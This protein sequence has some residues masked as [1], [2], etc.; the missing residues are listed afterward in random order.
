[1]LLTCVKN[2]KLDTLIAIFNKYPD[3][4]VS[5]SQY[6][7]NQGKMG[8]PRIQERQILNVAIDRDN[9]LEWVKLLADFGTDL[10]KCEN[11]FVFPNSIGYKSYDLTPLQEAIFKNKLN[12][13]EFLLE[14]G[15][16]PDTGLYMAVVTTRN[17]EALILLLNY[18]ADPYAYNGSI[19]K[20]AIELEDVEVV[21]ISHWYLPKQGRVPFY[22]LN[23]I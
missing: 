18:G 15:I 12:V 8:P 11:H 10:N 2:N 1:M 17:V 23:Q 13:L 19:L 3:I 7:M 21:D 16:N 20:E 22:R 9:C 4:K 14:R 6:V 5:G